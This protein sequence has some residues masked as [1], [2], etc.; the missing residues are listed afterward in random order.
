MAVMALPDLFIEAEDGAHILSARC[1][2]CGT[3]FFPRYHEQHRPGCSPGGRRERPAREGGQARKLHDPVLPAPA[4]F[5]D[6]NG[7]HPLRDRSRRVP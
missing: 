4:S 6:C 5:Q 2:S 7:Y 1:N 3:Y